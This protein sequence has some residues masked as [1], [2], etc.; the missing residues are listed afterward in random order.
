M[1]SVKSVVFLFLSINFFHLIW[2]ENSTSPSF[3]SNSSNLINQKDPELY[4]I[5]FNLNVSESDLF[6]SNQSSDNIH[7]LETT[8]TSTENSITMLT[9]EPDQV[10]VSEAMNSTE[11]HQNSQEFNATINEFI[12]TEVNF[13]SEN[14]S[15]TGEVPFNNTKASDEKHQDSDEEDRDNIHLEFDNSQESY[16]NRESTSDE[17]SQPMLTLMLNELKVK[18]EKHK[19]L[20]PDEKFIEFIS[21]IKKLYNTVMKNL[22]PIVITEILTADISV[23]CLTGLAKAYEAINNNQ[24]WVFKSKSHFDKLTR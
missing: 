3:S 23:G 19:D 14:S 7:G 2:M 24:Q 11:S 22:N 8:L 21:K 1:T 20:T 6:S 16:E 12:T 13:N 17:K 15:L 18:Q 9:T 4:G 10:L 5:T